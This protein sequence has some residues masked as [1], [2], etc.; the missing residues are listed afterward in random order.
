MTYITDGENPER[1]VIEHFL[2]DENGKPLYCTEKLIKHVEEGKFN[3]S[4]F[5]VGTQSMYDDVYFAITEGK[6]MR[7][8]PQMASQIIGVIE[9]VHAEN[10]LPLK[11]L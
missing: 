3:G 11:F 10:P 9:T 1:P 6:P 8:T 7:I 5:D 2:E 4:A